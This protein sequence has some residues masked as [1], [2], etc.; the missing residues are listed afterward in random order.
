[1]ISGVSISDAEKA[2]VRA[3][4]FTHLAGLAVA[5]TVAALWERGA[6]HVL[7]GAAGAVEFSEIL[8]RTHANAGYLRVALRL[9]ESCGWLT[10][11]PGAIGTPIG[12]PNEA[13]GAAA[14]LGTPKQD[15]AYN[16]T[17]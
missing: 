7:T 16:H 5:P 8:A 6:I 10:A 15:L 13:P 4:I 1:M 2:G 14:A 17:D 11:Q 12:T 9:L 3:D